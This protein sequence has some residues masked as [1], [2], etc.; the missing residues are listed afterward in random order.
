MDIEL[1]R[2]FVEVNRTRHFGEAAE[3]LFITQAA[4]SA[5]IKLLE[6]NLG[7][8]LFDRIK[9]DIQL[10][11]EGHRLLP[12]AQSLIANWQKARQEI[13]AGGAKRQLSVGGTAGLWQYTLP[14]WF[15]ALREKLPKVALITESH[16]T[17]TLTRHLVTGVVDVAFMLEPPQVEALQLKEVALVQLILV[18][19][20]PDINVEQA[21][22]EGY[23]MTDWGVAHEVAHRRTFP[24][25]PEPQIRVSQA[26]LAH[27][28]LLDIGGSAYLPARLVT[29]DIATGQL[30]M[31]E[32]A[33]SFDY[34]VYGVYP[35]RSA[36]VELIKKALRLFEY[37]VDLDELREYGE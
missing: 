33:P 27:R 15:I 21:L 28:H 12:H 29:D 10:T 36:K 26:A 35:I 17:T 18:S 3:A 34:P 8:R 19:H 20:Q 1:L 32:D 9:R 2:T 37:K 5:R 14:E 24:D 11:P 6:T 30:H 13:T 23:I 31:V 25:A 4:V 7:V 22:N 16:T